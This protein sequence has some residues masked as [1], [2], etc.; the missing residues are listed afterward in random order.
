MDIIILTYAFRYYSA[1]SLLKNATDSQIINQCFK[2][3][4]DSICG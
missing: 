1:D 3:S 4:Y 2:I